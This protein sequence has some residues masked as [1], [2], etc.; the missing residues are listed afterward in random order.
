MN[1]NLK[2]TNVIQKY[3][4]KFNK[5]Y[6]II[7]GHSCAYNLN[8]YNQEFR[9]TKDFDVVLVSSPINE[10]FFKTL[11][12][13]IEDGKYSNSYSNDKKNSFRFENPEIQGFPEV[14]ELFCEDGVFSSSLDKHL[15]KL[16]IK[17]ANNLLS[18]IVLDKDVY[19][20][21]LNNTILIDNISILN[22]IGCV[23]LK[24]Y[25]YYQNKSLYKEK[26]IKIDESHKH[27]NDIINILINL[28]ES[29]IVKP[30]KL[31]KILFD[32]IDA[33]IKDIYLDKF[34]EQLRS[35]HVDKN[36]FIN[37][38]RKLIWIPYINIGVLH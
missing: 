13:F 38:F 14:F 34:K 3:F 33:F 6:F 9:S 29:D 30:N 28:P 17:V 35:K 26:K 23:V 1:N 11:I 5:S 2:Y 16:N 10:D 25:A 22:L 37:L 27:L 21:A 32:N 24:I 31:P 20:F 36:E 8:Y 15:A 4:S 19:N 12:K 7:G 18:A